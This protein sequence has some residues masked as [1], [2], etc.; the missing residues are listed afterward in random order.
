MRSTG[1][2]VRYVAAAAVAALLAAPLAAERGGRGADIRWFGLAPGDFDRAAEFSGRPL[3]VKARFVRKLDRKEKEWRMRGP[4]RPGAARFIVVT[5]AGE[6]VCEIAP[7]SPGARLIG[8]MKRATPL[9]LAGR[10]DPRNYVFRVG[11][12]RQGWGRAQLGPGGAR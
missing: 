12:L 5:A 6:I 4:A 7:A 3:R 8:A 10:L 1:C 11:E 2:V 9:V